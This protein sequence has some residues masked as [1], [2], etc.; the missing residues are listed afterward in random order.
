MSSLGFDVWM[1]IKNGYIVPSTPTNPDAKREYEN[2][3]KAKNTILSGLSDTEFIK[4]MHCT[5]AKATLDKLQSIYERDP[6]VKEAKP[7]NLRAQFES[8]KVKEDEK[9]ADCLQRVD[10]IVSAKRVLRENVSDEVIVKKV[11][12][13][14]TTRYDT[15]VFDIEE[16]KDLK[17]LSKDELFGSLSTYEMRT[18]NGETS[19]REVAFNSI[20]KGKGEAS[21]EEDDEDYNTVVA[22]FLRK[23]KKGSCKLPFKCFN[24]GK[25]GHFSS[26]FPYG[27]KDGD[28]KQ[29]KKSF[30]K[31]KIK[32]PCKPRR[33]S[34]RKKNN[35]LY[36]FEDDAMD[37][38]SVID[39]D[40]SEDEREVNIFMEQGELDDEQTT[41]D[42][43]EEAKAKVDLEGELVSALE[44]LRKVR[45]E[46]TKYRFVVAE[47]Q[48][49]LNKSLQE[50]KTT[51]SDF[52]IQ[53]E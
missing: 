21:H 39:G 23:L 3:A 26:K 32:K 46:Y 15:K 41:S 52:R 20:K 25:I 47:E 35:S 14:L 17:T 37:E 34:F 49:L 7:Q 9:I 10:E 43:E 22:N 4:V 6:K 42:K 1:S 19:K 40:C 13:S 48:E 44:E 24:C 5:S 38:E 16:V 50:S 31:D 45:K 51:I 28:E 27:D 53:L 11:L 29:N 36:T 33:R 8:L 12:R 30:G 18:I 2:S